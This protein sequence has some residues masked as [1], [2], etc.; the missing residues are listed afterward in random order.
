MRVNFSTL[1]EHRSGSSLIPVVA[2]VIGLLFGIVL[3][4]PLRH[5]LARPV[6]LRT[7]YRGVQISTAAG[8]VVVAATLFGAAALAVARSLGAETEVSVATA[9]STSA[10]AVAGFGLLGLVDDVAADE[11]S[12]GYLGH[13]RELARG[14]MTA[15][16]LKMLAG[17]AVA[18]LA[19]QPISG[20]RFGWLLLDGAIVALC[21]NF[22]NLLDT[23][24]ARVTKTALLVFVALMIGVAFV[25]TDRLALLVGAAVTVGAG[26]ALLVD[27]LREKL[28]LGDTGANPMGAVLGLAAVLTFTEVGRIVLLVVVLLLNLLSERFSFKK[29][30]N[31]VGPLRWFDQLGRPAVDND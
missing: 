22:A 5:L 1:R 8:L 25:D 19:V 7:N 2:W 27:E 24:P 6:F 29:V 16:S 12:S 26:S 10:L 20:D 14:R 17:P 23:G 11:G 28:M 9:M 31:S 4:H 3:L 15:G 13:V 21:A 18:I 30:I